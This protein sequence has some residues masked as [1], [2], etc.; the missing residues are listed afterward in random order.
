MSL[1]DSDCRN[2]FGELLTAVNL[3]YTR[4]AVLVAQDYIKLKGEKCTT[5]TSLAKL[6]EQ[7]TN[8]KPFSKFMTEYLPPIIHPFVLSVPIEIR[9]KVASVAIN[10]FHAWVSLSTTHCGCRF[11]HPWE[12]RMDFI[13]LVNVAWNLNNSGL[14]EKDLYKKLLCP[15]GVGVSEEEYGNILGGGANIYLLP[16]TPPSLGNRYAFQKIKQE[17]QV[18]ALSLVVQW[19]AYKNDLSPE[20]VHTQH[21]GGDSRNLWKG[22]KY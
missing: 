19:R 4:C 16:P 15:N 3:L 9:I 14:I 18:V 5:S 8:N 12:W 22:E 10:N 11:F 20:K 7:I 2:L 6:K 21:W 17:R 1:K 13:P